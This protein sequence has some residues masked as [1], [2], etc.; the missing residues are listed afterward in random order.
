HLVW[1]DNRDGAQGLRYARSADG[2]RSWS[3][4]LTLDART[5]ECCWN[6]IAAGPDGSLAV[7]YRDKDPRDM[8]VVHSTDGGRTWSR[9]SAVGTFGWGIEGCPHVGG[10]VVL[11]RGERGPVGLAVVWNGDEGNAGAFLARSSRGL[12]TWLNTTPIA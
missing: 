1:L 12:R 7:L 4:N 3:A 5:C 6:A 11:T 8:A 9:P 2:G 10:S